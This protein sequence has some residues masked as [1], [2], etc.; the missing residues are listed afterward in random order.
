[1]ETP[2]NK[3]KTIEN[4]KNEAMDG[5]QTKGGG[6]DHCYVN[7]EE[8]SSTNPDS[9]GALHQGLNSMDPAGAGWEHDASSG[10]WIHQ[11]GYYGYQNRTGFQGREGMGDA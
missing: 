1:M 10:A 2:E 5:S 4:F 9:Y 11:T 6:L 3:N 7:M 8:L